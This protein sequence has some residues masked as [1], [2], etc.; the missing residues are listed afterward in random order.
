MLYDETDG[1]SSSDV[2]MCQ[3]SSEQTKPA[4][5]KRVF[6]GVGMSPGTRGSL[7]P[8]TENSSII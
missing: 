4:A 2:G 6:P 7:L 5:A 3:S 8:R 1:A